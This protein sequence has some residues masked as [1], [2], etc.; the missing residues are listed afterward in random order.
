MLHHANKAK[1]RERER[2]R[3]KERKKE[4][5]TLSRHAA[6][7]H[8]VWFCSHQKW[9]NSDICWGSH[10]LQGGDEEHGQG[11][12][13]QHNNGYKQTDHGCLKMRKESGILWQE[14]EACT[15]RSEDRG[16]K[17]WTLCLPPQETLS[18]LITHLNI[19]IDN[20]CPFIKSQACQM[21]WISFCLQS[22]FSLWGIH[23]NITSL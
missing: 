22:L 6:L 18:A 23:Q 2:E 13:M 1:K 10:L 14:K 8:C 17:Q 20:L 16:L 7:Q 9:L 19:C 12:Q 4:Q 15:I 3:K 21:E 5:T 11:T